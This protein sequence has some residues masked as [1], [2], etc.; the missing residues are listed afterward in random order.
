MGLDILKN[1][2]DAETNVDEIV[3]TNGKNIW[4]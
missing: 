1:S 3:P 2:L 4:E